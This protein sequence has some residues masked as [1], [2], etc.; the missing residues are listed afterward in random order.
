MHTTAKQKLE[1]KD[2]KKVMHRSVGSET[3]AIESIKEMSNLK[4]EIKKLSKTLKE[5]VKD[6]MWIK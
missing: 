4:I 5:K 1:I 2:L 3:R 6:Q